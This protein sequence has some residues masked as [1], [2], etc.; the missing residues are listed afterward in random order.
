MVLQWQQH[1]RIDG[2]GG[3]NYNFG[4]DVDISGNY[5]IGGEPY[6]NFNGTHSGFGY[7]KELN[8]NNYWDNSGMIQ[9]EYFQDPYEYM[10][11]S[12]AISGI[13]AIVGAPGYN[14]GNYVS[15]I[16]NYDYYQGI[17]EI[18][19]IMFSLLFKV[20]TAVDSSIY[21]KSACVKCQ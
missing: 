8:L 20:S 1:Q 4:Y 9:F 7:T 11:K 2:S 18:R 10:C 17:P 14:Y 15:F 16:A 19:N 3:A 6:A 5:L 13:Y 12:V 21:H